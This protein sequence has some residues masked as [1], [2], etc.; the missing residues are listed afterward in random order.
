MAL[1]HRSFGR[2]SDKNSART[3]QAEQR[4]NPHL[5]ATLATLKMQLPS[6]QPPCRVA[7]LRRK[8]SGYRE[9]AAQSKYVNVARAAGA[10]EI[11]NVWRERDWG[12]AQI[13][14]KLARAAV[15]TFV[16]A[17]TVLRSPPS[18]RILLPVT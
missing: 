6:H 3:L 1:G 4:Y 14:F 17:Q 18:M 8:R 12:R 2:Y 13:R 10:A 7:S 5:C 16:R 11:Q 9:A 15:G